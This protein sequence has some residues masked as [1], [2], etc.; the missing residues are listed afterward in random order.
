MARRQVNGPSWGAFLE[1]NELA[2]TEVARSAGD[3]N[4]P[5]D[6]GNA[7]SKFLSYL[8]S[9]TVLGL[10]TSHLGLEELGYRGNSFSVECPGC[11]PS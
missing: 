5:A 1:L 9:Q 3:G 10:Y 4:W 11:K 7:G 2:Q 8:G 6:H